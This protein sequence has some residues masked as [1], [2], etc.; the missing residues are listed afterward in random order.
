[1]RR[2]QA[3]LNALNHLSLNLDSINLTLITDQRRLLIN[4]IRNGVPITNLTSQLL[5]YLLVDSNE[6][7]LVP[8][9]LHDEL[10]KS[11][12][13]LLIN[14]ATDSDS[15]ALNI[16]RNHTGLD[17]TQFHNYTKSLLYNQFQRC[18]FDAINT[19]N[20]LLINSLVDLR[21]PINLQE[22]ARMSLKKSAKVYKDSIGWLKEY[23]AEEPLDVRMNIFYLL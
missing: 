14:L 11:L 15:R 10:N 22:L 19:E 9:H 1:M 21:Q 20:K 18:C 4:L 5:I 13:Q 23:L 8:I 16:Y 6:F 2:F 7:Q 3:F 12:K 17:K